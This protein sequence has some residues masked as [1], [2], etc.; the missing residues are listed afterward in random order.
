MTRRVGLL[1][2]VFTP[3]LI[4]PG[5]TGEDGAD[6]TGEASVGSSPRLE[7]EVIRI[8]R[9]QITSSLELVG[10]LMPVRA[11]TIVADVDGRIKAFPQSNRKVDVEIG[12]K[13]R[14]LTL[15]LGLGHEVKQGDVLVQIDP[16]DFELELKVAKANLELVRRNLA[17]LLAWKRA[18]EVEQTEAQLEEASAVLE[19]ARADLDRSETLLGKK[20]TSQFAHDAIVMT[21][22]T[23]V[24]TKKHAEA[25][26][27]IA[28]AGPTEEETA[29]A[30]AQIAAAEA[31]VEMRAEK[32]A[33]TTVR[34]P[35]DAVIA[36]RYV[37]VGDRVT[38]MP[39]VEIMQLVDPRAVFAEVAVPERYQ[40]MVK[41]DNV[42][43]V[44][45]TG[46]QQ[47]MRGVVDLINGKIDPQTRTFR[48]RV[49]IDN[50]KRVFKPGGFVRVTLPLA[51]T[52]RALVVP[53]RAV[54][55]SEGQ[56]AVFVYRD[57]R[58]RKQPVSL[59]I[60]NR[61]DYEILS[62]ISEGDAV[63]VDKTSLLADGL[64]VRLRGA[65]ARAAKASRRQPVGL[66]AGLGLAGVEG[67][68]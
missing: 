15:G 60:S 14:S 21:Y 20:V 12:G 39:R 30:K 13:K 50:R 4:L 66:E 68:P 26:L 27:K 55:F 10:S 23:A 48:I 46:V 64:R 40:A 3:A 22:R 5:C 47:P 18:E 38:A 42:A 34:S 59:G 31:A 43:T 41:L 53:F 52:A 58:V 35:Y 44:R 11:T 36:D 37:D 1:L 32:L 54:T 62:G 57:G 25:A 9:S 63:V 2:L 28:K 16:V 19:R 67:K 65:G 29:V 33:K 45:A 51:S 7:V 17:N 6:R 49:A 8:G 61:N 24:A 56:P